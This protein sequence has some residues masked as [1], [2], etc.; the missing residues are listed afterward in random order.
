MMAFV[1]WRIFVPQEELTNIMYTQQCAHIEVRAWG[2]SYLKFGWLV[3]VF[4][5]PWASF[6]PSVHC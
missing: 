1:V 2:S 4:C 6:R 3:F 5:N